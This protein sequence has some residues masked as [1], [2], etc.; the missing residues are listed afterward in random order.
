VCG[1]D[2]N[3][4]YGADLARAYIEV[5]HTKSITEVDGGVVNPE[6]DLVPLCSNCHSMAHREHGRII[7]LEESRNL[8]ARSG[9]AR[10]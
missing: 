9:A 10:V 4:F 3:Q 1:F 7:P 5:H 6:T 8:V 2:F